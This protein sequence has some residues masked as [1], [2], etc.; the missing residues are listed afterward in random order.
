[1]ATMATM[2]MRSMLEIGTSRKWS[3][4]L[5]SSFVGPQLREMG[6][7]GIERTFS[8][9]TLFTP[10]K[11]LIV[12]FADSELYFLTCPVTVVMRKIDGGHLTLSLLKTSLV[13]R[14]VCAPPRSE[15]PRLNSSHNR[16][17]RMPSS[18]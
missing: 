16:E 9:L 5:M 11:D 10:S 1:M 13:A 4:F 12:M 2:T 18:A 15:E 17:S 8:I 6:S 14:D 3:N 7:S